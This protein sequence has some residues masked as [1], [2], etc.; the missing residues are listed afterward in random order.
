[1]VPRVFIRVSVYRSGCKRRKPANRGTQL[2]QRLQVERSLPDDATGV[3]N[4]KSHVPNVSWSLS[5]TGCL[6]LFRALDMLYGQRFRCWRFKGRWHRNKVFTFLIGHWLIYRITGYCYSFVP[7]F[8]SWSASVSSP[9]TL[10]GSYGTTAYSGTALNAIVNAIWTITPV[11]SSTTATL[12]INWTADFKGSTFQG[13]GNNGIGISHYN[14][15]TWDPA[16]ATGGANHASHTV[17]SQFSS[18]SPFGVGAIGSSLPVTL[19]NFKAVLNSNKEV[20]LTWQTTQEENSDYF[21][22]E[23]SADGSSLDFNWYCSSPG[24]CSIYNQLFLS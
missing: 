14:G 11:T 4:L 21:D 1:M 10:N 9:A 5:A 20:N 24:Q 17:T 18:F 16:T 2:P 15:T 23:R 6:M 13:Y 7:V 12:T 8:A 22:V 3:I 19:I